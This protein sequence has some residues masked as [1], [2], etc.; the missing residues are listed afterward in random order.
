MVSRSRR[1]HRYCLLLAFLVLPIST[2]CKDG[3]N[4]PP[5]SGTQNAFRFHFPEFG[6][7]L[8]DLDG[9]HAPDFVGGQCL[10]RTKD[11]YV[12]RVQ[13]QLSS[14]A[15]S[16]SFTVFHNNALG[17]K[18]TGVDID[19]DDDTDLIISDRFFGRHI[20]I[21]LNDGTGRFVQ[22]L[23]GLFSTISTEDLAFVAVDHNSPEQT[24]EDRQEQRRSDGLPVAGYF[25]PL[26]LHSSESNQRCG[27]WICNFAGDLL[28]QRAPPTVSS[29]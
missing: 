29:V 12:Y 28:H 20:G 19:G 7:L 24:T 17:F 6:S 5:A 22:S 10:G 13:L 27:E 14:G 9:D 18:I 15:P 21:W 25:Q 26:P 23:P 11:G 1:S 2:Y 3:A 16:N 8:G 4:D